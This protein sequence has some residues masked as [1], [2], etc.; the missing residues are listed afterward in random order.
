VSHLSL[1]DGTPSAFVWTDGSCKKDRWGGWGVVAIIE[2][3]TLVRAS[4]CAADTTNNR[5]EL[6]AAIEGIK[7]VPE[8]AS[9]LVYSDSQYVVKSA[10][11]WMLGWR[12]RG[13]Y[14][15]DGNPVSNRDLVRE[16]DE[17]IS[18]RNVMFQ[19]VKGH[20]G[21][22]MNEAADVLADTAAQRRSVHRSDRSYPIEGVLL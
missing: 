18:S 13:Y 3:E 21:N 9:V 2:G 16:L 8:G 11:Q 5:M 17:A 15:S 19:W 1:L 22:Q 6:T 14:K 7:M 10:M 12:S 4:G 20:S